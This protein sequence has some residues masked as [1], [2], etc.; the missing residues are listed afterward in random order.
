M[1]TGKPTLRANEKKRPFPSYVMPRSLN[2]YTKSCWV[3]GKAIVC[4]PAILFNFCHSAVLNFLICSHL[5]LVIPLIEKKKYIKTI[6]S[7][8]KDCNY[9]VSL[10]MPE[11]KR[12][13]FVSWASADVKL[14]QAFFSHSLVCTIDLKFQPS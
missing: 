4:L 13:T 5:F 6:K 10:Q 14:C 9:L 12:D 7:S 1:G 11:K 3:E 8:I 2:H